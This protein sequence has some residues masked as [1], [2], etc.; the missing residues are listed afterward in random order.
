MTQHRIKRTD[1]EWFDLI[2]DCQTSGLKVKTWCEHHDFTAKALYY[3]MRQF[4]KKGFALAKRIAGSSSPEKQEVVCLDVSNGI[5]AGALSHP[6]IDAI[7]HQLSASI[8]MVSISEYPTMRRR[9]RFGIHSACCRNCVRRSFRS[10][11]DLSDHRPYRY[12][13]LDQW[14]HGDHP[15]YLSNGSLCKCSLSF[16]RQE[17][18]PF[19]S[20]AS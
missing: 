10:I 5:S 6:M 13:S 15:G 20:A 16:L 17:T 8:F 9:I 2:N 1:Q 4:R 11:Q 18:G 12:A 14:T 3:H 7:I 19:K